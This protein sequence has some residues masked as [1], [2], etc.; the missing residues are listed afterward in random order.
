ME[1]VAGVKRKSKRKRICVTGIIESY[2]G[3]PEIVVHGPD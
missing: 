3:K 2:R 1:N